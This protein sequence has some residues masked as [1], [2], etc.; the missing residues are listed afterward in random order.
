MPCWENLEK[1]RVSRGVKI[2]YAKVTQDYQ[3]FEGAE[4][5]MTRSHPKGQ[6]GLCF[7]RWRG[8]GGRKQSLTSAGPS[9]KPLGGRVS[10]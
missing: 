7:I 3:G 1:Q 10:I 4:T 9:E 8:V 2:F 6:A 5:G